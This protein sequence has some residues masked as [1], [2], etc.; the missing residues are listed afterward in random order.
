MIV[1]T[2]AVGSGVDELELCGRAIVVSV[3]LL[4]V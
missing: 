3:G 4:K 2:D 1:L